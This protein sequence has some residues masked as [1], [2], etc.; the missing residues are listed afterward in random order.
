MNCVRAVV[1]LFTYLHNHALIDI[2]TAGRDFIHDRTAVT[3]VDEN[4][5]PYRLT[6][7]HHVAVV[8]AGGA[9]LVVDDE[10]FRAAIHCATQRARSAA[11]RRASRARGLLKRARWTAVRERHA[12]DLLNDLIGP[13]SSDDGIVSPRTQVVHR[14]TSANG[15]WFH[16]VGVHPRAWKC[17]EITNVSHVELGDRV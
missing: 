15:A 10:N 3:G 7:T 1:E 5:A 2:E 11:A 16:D 17:S 6:D 8:V 9:L 4:Q 14:I 12:H 13:A